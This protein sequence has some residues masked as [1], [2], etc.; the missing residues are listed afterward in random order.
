MTADLNV[1]ETRGLGK[2]YGEQW[3]LR[4]CTLV[5]P[6]GRVVGLVGPNGAGKT[7]L[8]QLAVGILAPSSGEIAVFG[9]DPRE[10]KSVLPRIG[11]VAQD[12]PLY[13]TFSVTDTLALGRHLNATFDERWGRDRL[14][15]LRIPLE[16]K[17]DEL[18]SGQRAQVALAVALAKRPQLLVLDEPVASLDPL[19]RRE[20]LTALMDAVAEDGLSVIL[21]SHLLADLEHSCD[22][23]ILLMGSQVRLDGDLD[24]LLA[25]HRLL[26]GPRRRAMIGGG[27]AAVVRE[28]HSD[29]QST[30]LVRL[31][32]PI[33]D[34]AWAVHEV[35]LEELVLAYMGAQHQPRLRALPPRLEAN[36]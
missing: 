34:P 36:G 35:D 31:D 11:F 16:R 14:R 2:R 6:S 27:I 4:D 28:S 22:Y 24:E 33:A 19:A 15:R 7:T 5:L 32:G 12:S 3:A 13:R 23:L 21:S 8:L 9:R 25:A 18:S 17:I 30:L 26:I 29:R 20:F 1:L 10:A